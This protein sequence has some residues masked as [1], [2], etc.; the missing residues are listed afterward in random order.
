MDNPVGWIEAI[1]IG[2]VILILGF[3]LFPGVNTQIA[4]T[5]TTGWNAIA[6]ATHSLTPF[7]WIGGVFLAMMVIWW[8]KGK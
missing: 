7:F 8:R 3:Y 4:S 6:A 2:F 5:N 1:I